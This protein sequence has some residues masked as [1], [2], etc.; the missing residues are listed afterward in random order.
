MA[1]SGVRWWIGS[2]S[3]RELGNIQEQREYETHEIARWNAV[4][5]DKI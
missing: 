5:K 2:D 3:K 1:L 4:G